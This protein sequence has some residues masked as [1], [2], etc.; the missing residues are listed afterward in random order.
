MIEQRISHGRQTTSTSP[1]RF[2]A[3]SCFVFFLPWALNGLY[4]PKIK[5]H[6]LLT[7]QWKQL[8]IAILLCLQNT[9]NEAA[10]R[11]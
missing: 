5:A 11:K 6:V 2:M 4:F 10:P 1:C 8:Q 7:I 9:L 3:N